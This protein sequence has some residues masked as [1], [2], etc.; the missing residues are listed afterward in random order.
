VPQK[1]QVPMQ[2][3]ATTVLLVQLPPLRYGH[4]PSVLYLCKPCGGRLARRLKKQLFDI[5]AKDN[6]YCC[7]IEKHG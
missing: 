3:Q 6:D 2:R 4:Q 7:L 1:G 5:A